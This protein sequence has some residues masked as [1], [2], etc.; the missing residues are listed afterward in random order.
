MG[1]I[2]LMD[3]GLGGLTVLRQIFKQMPTVST[4]YFADSGRT[5]YGPRSKNEITSFVRQIL[6]FL[7]EKGI[8]LSILACNTATA[9]ALDTVKDEFQFP[10][11]GIIKPGARAALKVTKNKKIGVIGT[12]FTIKSGAYE[13]TI[14]SLDNEADVISQAC[15][16]FCD[17]VEAG[18]VSGKEVEN[19]VE[20]YISKYEKSNI[21]TLVLGCTHYPVLA[22]VIKKF[23]S[24]DVAIVDPAVE[25]VA[26][27]KLLLKNK[28]DIS[29]KKPYHNF[30]TSGKASLF[31]SLGEVI[32]DRPIQTVE[33]VS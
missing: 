2:G 5:P 3:S 6:S 7:S 33:E 12:E 15:P 21:D 30:Y 16:P 13:K 26:E 31:S 22:P 25:V 18:K 11:L 14:K 27:A 20:R 8:D 32:L 17:L 4:E 24:P 1:S 29:T 23:L 19:I 10:I 9:A 28:M